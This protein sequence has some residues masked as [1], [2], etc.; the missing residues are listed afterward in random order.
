MFLTM[1]VSF[2][3]QPETRAVV[4]TMVGELLARRQAK[5]KLDGLVRSCA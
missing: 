1:R 2:G 4:V 5:L 3:E